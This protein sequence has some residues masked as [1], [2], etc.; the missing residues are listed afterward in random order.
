[1]VKI[2]IGNI[3][4]PYPM[5]LTLVGTIVEG[6]I[7]FMPVGWVTRVNHRP[8]IWAIA[9]NRKH[10]TLSGIKEVKGFSIN[11][12]DK[13]LLEKTDYCGLVSG[14]NIDKSN[15]FEV[16]YGELKTIPLISDCPLNIEC[17]LID[18]IDQP[19]NQL[20]RGEVVATYSE[21]R[22]LTNGKPD[23]PKMDLVVFTMPDNKY[24]A[25]GEYIAKAWNVGKN[26]KKN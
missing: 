6:K 26:F 19:S 17:E 25:I 11:F 20:I 2:N 18:I 23:I 21:D 16:F 1:M 13:S 15:I 24:W 14:K 3:V 22:Y 7:N 9:I 12:P 10:Y 8:V 5:P 4:S